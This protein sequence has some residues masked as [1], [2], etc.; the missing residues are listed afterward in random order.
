MDQIAAQSA[1]N[2]GSFRRSIE[3]LVGRRAG[4][5]PLIEAQQSGDEL[6]DFPRLNEGSPPEGGTL[7]TVAAAYAAGR[8]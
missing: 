5:V 4:Q 3:H 7:A 1:G 2:D 6:Y 8:K